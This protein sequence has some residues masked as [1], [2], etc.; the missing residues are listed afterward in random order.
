LLPHLTQRGVGLTD[1]EFV[2]GCWRRA[3]L[4]LV[5]DPDTGGPLAPGDDV[6][7]MPGRGGGAGRESDAL[8]HAMFGSTGAAGCQSVAHTFVVTAMEGVFRWAGY[9][10]AHEPQVERYHQARGGG[11][12]RCNMRADFATLERDPTGLKPAAV[13][14]YDIVIADANVGVSPNAPVNVAPAAGAVANKREAG[15]REHYVSHFIGPAS[16]FVGLG[17]QRD[18]SLG[19]NARELLRRMARRIA[20]RSGGS[21]P[22]TVALRLVRERVATA[23]IRGLSLFI[24]AYVHQWRLVSAKARA[25]R[26]TAMDNVGGDDGSSGG[27]RSR[28]SSVIGAGGNIGGD[29]SE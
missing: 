14:L 11:A 23:L 25:E 5:V 24:K 17:F 22:Y 20:E 15:K 18:G 2:G 9:T 16:S 12:T 28:A 1:D 8:G 27:G 7:V 10:V 19:D 4:P 29:D 26:R 13:V 6:L 21:L 3:G